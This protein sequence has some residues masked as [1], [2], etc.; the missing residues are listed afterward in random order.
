MRHRIRGRKLNRTSAHRRAMLKSL[1]CGLFLTKPDEENGIFER[2]ITTREKAKEARRLADKV[3]T[4]GKRGTLAARRRAI[5]LLD[6][7]TVVR[8]VFEEVA[9]RYANRPGGYTRIIG[10]PSNRLGDNARQVIFELV[11]P[12]E[13]EA[14]PQPSRPEVAQEASTKAPQAAATEEPAADEEAVAEDE[15]AEAG[16]E[17]EDKEADDKPEK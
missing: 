17:S 9:P 13:A 6:N 15:N 4:L 14:A 10:Y 3:I 2:V 16:E 8:R 1:V 7:K 5:Q 11:E 12:L